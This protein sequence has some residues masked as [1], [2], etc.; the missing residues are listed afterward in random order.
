[1]VVI[2]LALAAAFANAIASICQRLGVEDAPP[3]RGPSMG[4]VR[5]MIRRPIWLLGFLIMGLGYASQAVALHLG[6]LNVVQPLMI[7]ELVILVLVLWLW[8]SSPLRPRDFVS[9]VAAAIGL[10][11]F[12]L[13]AAPTDG[14]KV[15]SNALWLVVGALIVVAVALLSLLARGGPPWRQAMLL[16][17]AAS[18]GFAL[19]SA[20]TKS[21]TNLLVTGW[22][23]L[24]GSWPL[25]ALCVIGL[26]SFVIMQS[27]FQVGP[28]AASQSTLILVN[29]FVSILIGHLLYGESLRGGPLYLSLEVLSLAVMVAGA[30]G[31]STSSLIATV[32]EEHSDGH[33]LKGR[34]RYGR[35]RQRSTSP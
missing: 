6:S 34:G 1:M 20:I 8:Y 24:F 26:G 19:L 23:A 17:A 22:G 16:G 13:L 11:G 25:Y 9:A 31:L 18:V 7:S 10:G 15:P 12:L 2:T 5:Y 28:F 14:T 33:L 21:M 30:L 3:A 32:H 35:W 29:P 4:L 27:A